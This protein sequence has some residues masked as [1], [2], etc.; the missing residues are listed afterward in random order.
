MWIMQLSCSVV[1]VGSEVVVDIGT[2]QQQHASL[3]S[4]L[5]AATTGEVLSV[6]CSDQLL[7][8]GERGGMF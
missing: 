4:W 2:T 1:V 7:G 3:K 8:A 5:A 6:I